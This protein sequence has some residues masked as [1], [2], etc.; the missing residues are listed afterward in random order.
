MLNLSRHLE[1]LTPPRSVNPPMPAA[2]ILSRPC[3][4]VTSFC[5]LATSLYPPSP[6]NSLADE[7][8]TVVLEIEPSTAFPR[9][10]EGAFVSLASKRILFAYTQ[11]Y[12]GARDESPARIV[13]RYSDD[14]GRTW[15]STDQVLVENE[16]TAN[17]M[18]VSL[19]RL[20][21]GTL[22]LFYLRKNSWIDCRPM[23]RFSS[24]EGA[25]WSEP[26]VMT[27]APGYFV[28]NNDRVIQLRSG[29]LVAPLAFHRARN[30]APHQSSS[31][32][33]RAIALWLLSDDEGLTWREAKDWLSLP[34]TNTRTGLQEPGV[35][36][37]TDGELLSWFRT[38]QG[39]QWFSRSSDSGEHWSLPVASSLL[40][41]VA[42][43]SIQRWPDSPWLLGVWNDHSTDLAAASGK[44]TPLAAAL[45]LDA[46]A[47]W[48]YRRLL[49][50]DPEGWYC[51]TAIEATSEAILLAYCAGDATVGKLNRL[52]IRRLPIASWSLPPATAGDNHRGRRP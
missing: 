26:R 41:P 40:S 25:S 37:L 47:S 20:Q 21:S 48:G 27:H 32:D 13:A 44:R 17:V 43:A 4:V 35:V 10:S 28:M 2:S 3:L 9:N 39:E 11:F 29:R 14:G 45:S 30:D 7:T 36:E 46:G 5:L 24:D 15:S 6:R 42:P 22:A 38:D 23:V 52:R 34:V 33:S 18:S 51:Y 19:L 12:G 50:S 1:L 8:D 16:G 49:E 31:F